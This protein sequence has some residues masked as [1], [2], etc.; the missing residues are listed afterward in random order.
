MQ[1]PKKDK[2]E[3]NNLMELCDYLIESQ[4]EEIY[5]EK[6]YENRREYF[7]WLEKQQTLIL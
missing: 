4:I 6:D 2:K 3:M 5:D 7:E 1:E